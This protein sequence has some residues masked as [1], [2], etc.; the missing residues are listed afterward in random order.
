MITTPAPESG[1]PE[2]LLTTPLNKLFC[3]A[4]TD[5]PDDINTSVS[6]SNENCLVKNCMYCLF[7]FRLILNIV[8]KVALYS[9]GICRN[10][11]GFNRNMFKTEIR[12]PEDILPLGNRHLHVF[13]FNNCISSHE[14][15]QWIN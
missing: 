8:A 12:E 15:K 2:L 1:V 9:Y 13:P 7:L 10:L 5:I 14:A 4:E 3:C 6:N 11:Y